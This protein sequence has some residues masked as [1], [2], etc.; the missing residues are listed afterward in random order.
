MNAEQATTPLFQRLLGPSFNVLPAPLRHLHDD[1]THKIFAGRCRIERGR[2]WLVPLFAW[3]MSLPKGGEDLPVQIAIDSAQRRETW[4][5]NFAGQPMRSTLSEHDGYLVERMGPMGFRF[6]L[7]VEGQ[8]IVWTLAGVRLLG[9]LPLPLA[10]FS[11]VT[12]RES[13]QSD[14]YQFDVR[15]ALPFVGPLIHYRGWLSVEP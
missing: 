2:H 5:R 14:R 1:R 3:V 4:A 10:W 8:A 13:M 7:R 6:A 9:L 11:G 15:A 12:A